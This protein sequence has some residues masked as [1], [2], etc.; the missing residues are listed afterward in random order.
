MLCLRNSQ[1][2]TL[3]FPACNSIALP[4]KVPD[5]P[6]NALCF[7]YLCTRVRL[8]LPYTSVKWKYFTMY[9]MHEVKLQ[10]YAM[11]VICEY[12]KENV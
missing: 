7:K 12:V 8:I 10:I 1:I 6:P 4:T 11:F 2:W 5:Q 9:V 3:Y